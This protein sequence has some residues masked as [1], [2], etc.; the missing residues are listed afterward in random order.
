MIEGVEC[1]VVCTGRFY[2]FL[3]KRR[4]KW[5]MVLR[6][7]IYERDRLNPVDPTTAPKLDK[8]QLARFPVGY[9]HLAYLQSKI[10]YKVKPNM[11]GIDGPVV[12]SLYASGAEWLKGKKLNT[13]W[14]NLGL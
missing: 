12:T 8:A 4:G 3:E 13:G 2:D 9:R 7:P 6:Q 1:D 10:G 14:V 5:G 11:P